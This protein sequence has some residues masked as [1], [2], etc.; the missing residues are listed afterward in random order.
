MFKIYKRRKDSLINEYI[1]HTDKLARSEIEDALTK[2]N[3]ESSDFIYSYKD[4]IDPVLDDIL[5]P[6]LYERHCLIL[7]SMKY[8][9]V[10]VYPTYT[11]YIHTIDTDDEKLKNKKIYF[12][13]ND[14]SVD[15]KITSIAI[16]K[17]LIKSVNTKT[18]LVFE[19]D[20]D[21]DSYCMT[22]DHFLNNFPAI[23]YKL[24]L[25]NNKFII[26]DAKSDEIL[27]VLSI[28]SGVLTMRPTSNFL[29]YTITRP[30]TTSKNIAIETFEQLI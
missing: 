26:H 18:G 25:T 9:C 16:M 12:S 20:A 11:K 28:E 5:D 27:F 2:L 7:G 17:S 4:K 6:I 14:K 30:T 15:L 29:K 24:D 8:D 13:V 19:T 1:G 3:A 22:I 23:L 21:I 10:D